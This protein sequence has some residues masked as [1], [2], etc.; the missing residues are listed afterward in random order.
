MS[1]DIDAIMAS[2]EQPSEMDKQASATTPEADMTKEAAREYGRALAQSL[3]KQANQINEDQA[4]IAATQAAQ[5]QP[6]PDGSIDDVLRAL[7]AQAEQGGGVD[8]DPDLEALLARVAANLSPNPAAPGQGKLLAT[9]SSPSDVEKVAALAELLDQGVDYDTAAEIVKEAAV[10]EGFR[11]MAGNATVADNFKAMGNMAHGT[12]VVMKELLTKAY[13]AG[14]AHGASAAKWAGSHKG[15]IA[16]TVGA[17][18]AGAGAVHLY[19]KHRDQEKKAALDSLLEA[20]MDFDTASEVVKEAAVEDSFRAQAANAGVKDSFKAMGNMAHGTG[21]VAKEL[22]AKAYR[23]GKSGAGKAVGFAGKHKGALAAAGAAGV[24]GAGAMH[25]YRKHKDQEKK[26]A[27]DSLIDAGVDFDTASE[28]AKEAAVEDSFRAQ[29]ANAGVK[30]SFKAMGNMAHGTGVVAKELLAKA[31]RAGKSGAGKAVGFAG[32]H[33]GALAAAGAAGVAGAGAMHLL[34]K[35]KD[36][37]K[38]ASFD[39]LIDA[40]VD[41]DTA[42]EIVADAF[43]E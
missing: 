13:K 12:G 10:P 19:N 28:L 20:G 40:G 36:Q 7:A 25:L 11:D 23:A 31:Y 43:A 26:A 21:V 32:K 14:A 2:L 6:T 3:I 17:G 9:E 34:N 35:R 42:S 39:S 33:K 5:T 4:A 27:F 30:D 18:A 37:E 1:F 15:A 8:E 29:A 16:A 41:F 38:K 24:A 22:L